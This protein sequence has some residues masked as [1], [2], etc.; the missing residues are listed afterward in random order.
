M[1]EMK[2]PN[3]GQLIKQAREAKGLSLRQL[4]DLVSFSDM[5]EEDYQT[6]ENGDYSKLHTSLLDYIAETLDCDYVS[7]LGGE[8]KPRKTPLE[9]LEELEPGGKGSI[10]ER[11]IRLWLHAQISKGRAAEILRIHRYDLEEKDVRKKVKDL[12]CTCPDC[13]LYMNQK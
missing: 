11:A 8:I 10:E 4:A 3:Y 6:I 7:F 12:G 5:T 2:E 1:E 9:E 13:R